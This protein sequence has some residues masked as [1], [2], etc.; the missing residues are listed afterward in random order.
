MAFQTHQCLW[1]AILTLNSVVAGNMI[2]F[3]LRSHT[4]VAEIPLYV[5]YV[6]I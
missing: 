2:L 1:V 5:D 6:S 3:V 4:L